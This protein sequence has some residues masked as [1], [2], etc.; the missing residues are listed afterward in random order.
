MRPGVLVPA[1]AMFLLLSACFQTAN[2]GNRSTVSFPSGDRMLKGAVYKPDGAGPFKTV[3]YNHGSRTFPGPF[4]DLAEFYNRN[5]F[6]FFI[7]YR[8]GHGQSPGPSYE[9]RISKVPKRRG[10]RQA[11]VR[12]LEDDNRDVVA[13]ARWLKKQSFVLQSRIVMSGVSFGGIQTLLS[14]EKDLGVSAFIAFAPAAQ[15][16]RNRRLRARLADAVENAKA[17]I[18]L[19]QAEND[20]STGPSEML[21]PQIKAKN[22]L[23]RAKLYPSYGTTKRDGHRG[24]AAREDGIK[25]WGPDVL[26]FIAAVWSKK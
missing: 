7:P 24:F 21:G 4:D 3:I 26:A 8:T 9:K 10:F 16:W 12:L 22:P 11:Q 19:I 20:F 25:I 6:V 13:A 2:A 18:F 15:S 23:N 1:G 14:A 5:G 17:P